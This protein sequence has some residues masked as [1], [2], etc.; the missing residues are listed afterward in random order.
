MPIPLPDAKGREQILAIHLRKA[1]ESGLV[2]PDVNDAFLAQETKD[3]SGADLA[4]LV[5]SA[6]SFAIADWRRREDD[7]CDDGKSSD[8]RV[9]PDAGMSSDVDAKVPPQGEEGDDHGLL[10]TVDHFAKAISE[11][12]TRRGGGRLERLGA[13]RDGLVRGLRRG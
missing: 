4:G 6:S 1:R 11:V 5:R 3:F 13:L 12:G 8:S 10:I 2:S 7:D 9:A